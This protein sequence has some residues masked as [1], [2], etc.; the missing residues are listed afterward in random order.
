MQQ[1]IQNELL[2]Y[3]IILDSKPV[4][5]FMPN[6][7]RTIKI[8]IYSKKTNTIVSTVEI[9]HFLSHLNQKNESLLSEDY[10]L[11]WAMENNDADTLEITDITN[12]FA[13]CPEILKALQENDLFYIEKIWV[14][15]KYRNMGIGTIILKLIPQWIKNFSDNENPVFI[16]IPAPYEIDRRK[17]PQK[18]NVVSEY[19][20]KYYSKNNF[21][22]MM[23][24]YDGM[25]LIA[26]SPI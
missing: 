13:A 8:L 22:L 19:L 7:V 15:P 17:N 10:D 4:S 23:D 6:E 21:K 2:D 24:E 5:G 1:K 16:L 18:Y 12:R 20:Q 9:K 14:V 11:F 3:S 26:S 25:Y